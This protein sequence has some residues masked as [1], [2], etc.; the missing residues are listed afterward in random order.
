[1]F[2]VAWKEINSKYRIVCKRKAFKSASALET[3]IDRL[4]EKDTFYEIIGYRNPADDGLWHRPKRPLGRRGSHVE[5][6]HRPPS[7][8]IKEDLHHVHHLRITHRSPSA[9]LHHHPYHVPK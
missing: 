8:Q 7:F 4:I 1:M 5:R 3:F 9:Q 6:R 2:E